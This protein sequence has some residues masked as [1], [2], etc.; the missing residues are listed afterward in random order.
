MKIPIITPQALPKFSY[1]I[2]FSK[3]F[4]FLEYL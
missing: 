4:L 2:K 3:F 1:E